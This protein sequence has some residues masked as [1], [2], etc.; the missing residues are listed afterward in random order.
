MN[1]RTRLWELRKTII[2]LRVFDDDENSKNIFRLLRCRKRLSN[3]FNEQEF[4]LIKSILYL[5]FTCGVGGV[6]EAK[7]C[8]HVHCILPNLDLLCR[9][10]HLGVYTKICLF[11]KILNNI[12]A[13]MAWLSAQLPELSVKA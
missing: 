11:F 1:M 12:T 13:A 10:V 6:F 2:R 9:L 7:L 8:V 3:S 5:I 4:R